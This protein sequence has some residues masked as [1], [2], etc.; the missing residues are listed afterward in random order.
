MKHISISVCNMK[1]FGEMRTLLKY[2]NKFNVGESN[3]KINI[4]LIR[5][6]GSAYNKNGNNKKF[7]FL[8]G[9]E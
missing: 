5:K 3:Y 4:K 1:I 7:S 2:R 8:N 9:K 6:N